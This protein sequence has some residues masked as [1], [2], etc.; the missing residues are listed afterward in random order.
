MKNNV[1]LKAALVMLT[2]LVVGC[3][4]NATKE[5]SAEMKKF[6]AAY[7]S[8]VAAVDKA[9]SVGGEWSNIRW[10]KAKAVKVKVKGKDGKTKTKKM[11]FLKA[12]KAYAKMGDFKKAH[13][14][15]K[16]SNFQANAGYQQA[17][18]QRTAKRPAVPP[19]K[20]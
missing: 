13:K 5:D 19:L 17:M 18:E 1:M 16:I 20:F 15:L 8:T 7:K 4:A 14:M 12:A 6:N 2:V 9:K 3:G 11:S 10:K